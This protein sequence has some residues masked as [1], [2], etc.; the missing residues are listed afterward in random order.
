MYCKQL[1]VHAAEALRCLGP[2]AKKAI[3]ALKEA[4]NDSDEYDLNKRSRKMGMVS[5]RIKL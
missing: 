2:L 4:Q 5:I 1:G 3:P